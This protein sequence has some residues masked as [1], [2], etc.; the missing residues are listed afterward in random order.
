MRAIL[1]AAGFGTRMY[2]LTKDVPKALLKVAGKPVIDYIFDELVQFSDLEQIT[3]VTNNRFFQQLTEWLKL[4]Q[5]QVSEKNIKL[6][7]LNDGVDTNETRLGAVGDLAFALESTAGHSHKTM[8]I[9]A[10]N[11]FN[12]QLLPL[13]E[14]FQNNQRNYLVAIEEKD[15]ARRQRSGILEI[16]EDQRVLSLTEKPENPISLFLCPPLYFLSPDALQKIEDFRDLNPSLDAPGFFISYLVEHLPF[17]ALPVTGGR[18]DI[19]S[20]E[21]FYLAEKALLKTNEK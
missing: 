16:A 7:L 11:I 10:D 2:P 1:L 3:I 4:W 21:D 5:G 8:I 14:T 9:A 12:F 17:Y 13:W 15:L 20:M 19:G 18:Y 6:N